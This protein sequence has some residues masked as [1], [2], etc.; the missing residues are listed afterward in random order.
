MKPDPLKNWRAIEALNPAQ[1]HRAG[2]KLFAQASTIGDTYLIEEGLVKLIHTD[3]RGREAIVGLRFPGWLLGAASMIVRQPSPV[4]AVTA[5]E[6]LLRPISA[7]QLLQLVATDVGTSRYLLQMLSQEIHEQ[8]NRTVELSQCTARQ[9]LES[10]LWDLLSH[11]ETI[12]T[13]RGIR[14]QFPLKHEEVAQLIA[15]TPSYLS[16]MLGRLEQQGFIRRSK[17]WIIVSD[18]HRLWH[19]ETPDI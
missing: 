17:G 6:C 15:V 16:R 2:S 13:A 14:L 5:T 18:P 8:L 19:Q 9:R 3:S 11:T 1:R 12:E 4:T 7:E 10:F